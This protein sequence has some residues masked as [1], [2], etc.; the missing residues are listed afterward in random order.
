MTP[1]RFAPSEAVFIT[2]EMQATWA[3]AG[4]PLELPTFVSTVRLHEIL[5][6]LSD[7]ELQ[8]WP[9]S[10]TAQEWQKRRAKEARPSSVNDGDDMA[11]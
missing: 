8:Q 4:A 10:M 9:P 11:A 7:D 5:A 2:E 3:A 6:G 1:Q